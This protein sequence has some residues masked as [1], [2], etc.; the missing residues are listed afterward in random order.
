M[1]KPNKANIRNRNLNKETLSPLVK[2][3]DSYTDE[4]I[5]SLSEKREN[6]RAKQTWEWE[7]VRRNSAKLREAA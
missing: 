4:L 5:K 3:V 7:Q 6:R 1:V 2:S